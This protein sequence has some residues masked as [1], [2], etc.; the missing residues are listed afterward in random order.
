LIFSSSPIPSL[1]VHLQVKSINKSDGQTLLHAFG[2]V[3]AI[4]N[5]TNDQ[6]SVC[7]GLGKLKAQRLFQAFHQPFLRAK[8]KKSSTSSSSTST[9]TSTTKKPTTEKFK[10]SDDPEE[11]FRDLSNID[12]EI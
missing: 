6:L 12:E 5:A 4:V 1:L 8:P 2:S 3:G 7:P 10:R 9:S 11:D